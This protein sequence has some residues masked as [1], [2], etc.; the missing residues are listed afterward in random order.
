MLRIIQII[1]LIIISML[2]VEGLIQSPN[3]NANNVT[4]IN[5]AKNCEDSEIKDFVI[6]TFKEHNQYYKDIDQSS[7][8]SITLM[9]PAATS[10][11]K[12]ID[13]YSCTGT[14]VM[15]APNGFLPAVYD[16]NNSYYTAINNGTTTMSTYDTLK[17]EVVY[18]SLISEGD[19]LVLTELK[20]DD[21]SC[22]GICKL[23]NNIPYIEEEKAK[24]ARQLA[25]QRQEKARQMEKQRDEHIDLPNFY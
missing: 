4:R 6:K 13:R 3:S 23:I 9:Y 15:T 10:Y 7:V 2:I 12:D 11:N 1:G 19:I 25:I 14:I 5:K 20:N 24:K 22:N 18:D 8:S 17:T 16:P 21:F